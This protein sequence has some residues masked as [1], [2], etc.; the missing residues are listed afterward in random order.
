MRILDLLQNAES[1][2]LR[3]FFAVAPGGFPSIFRLL[4]NRS[5]ETMV[6]LA[7][8]G[9]RAR[10]CSRNISQVLGRLGD[11]RPLRVPH[12]SFS[13][14]RD[15]PSQTPALVSLKSTFPAQI[16]HFPSWFAPHRAVS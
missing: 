6:S 13:R 11:E 12:P 14:G 9:G 1:R 16:P 8:T 2:F 15:F 3:G 10:V 5:I 7:H 4:E